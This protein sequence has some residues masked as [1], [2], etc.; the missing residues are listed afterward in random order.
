[1]SNVEK[2]LLELVKALAANDVQ[3]VV[4]G[5]IACVMHGVERNTFDVDISVQ[6]EESNLIKIINIAR[7]FDLYPR[8]PEPP[9]N[10]LD[11]DIRKSWIETKGALVYTFVSGNSPLQM[12]IFL[13][14][15]VTYEEL[16]SK[17]D[18]V[19]IDNLEIPI[20]SID[21]LIFAKKHVEPLRDKDKSD[22]ADL[23][24]INERKS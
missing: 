17:S 23:N 2:N 24:R 20:S 8:I 12:D 15:P 16:Y 4:C 11:E 5:G 6:L 1:M 18:R 9:E 22:I 19:V 13:K 21:D 14:Y 7:E 10:L 3:F